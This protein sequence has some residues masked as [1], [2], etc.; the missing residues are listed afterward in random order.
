MINIP[1]ATFS[2]NKII[3]F[4]PATEPEQWLSLQITKS[5]MASVNI[6]Q[7]LVIII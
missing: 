4:P 7:I 2:H 1:F 6:K 5:A 3:S